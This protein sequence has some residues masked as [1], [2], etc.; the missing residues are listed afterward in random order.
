MALYEI[1]F[2]PTGGTKK[3]AEILGSAWNCEAETID[4]MNPQLEPEK[5]S[6]SADDICIVAVPSF[7]GRAPETA[8]KRLKK[9]A[10]KEARA[11]LA[12]VYGNREFE[13]TLIELKDALSEAGFRCAA[14]VAAVAEHS[15][16]HKFGAGRPD[17]EDRQELK[18]FAERI[19]CRLEENRDGEGGEVSV[20]GGHPY[21]EYHGVPMKPK[22]GRDCIKCGKCAAECPVQAIPKD[23]LASVDKDRCISCMHCIAICPE[24]ARHNDKVVLF[25][26]EQKMKK[27]CSGRKANSLYL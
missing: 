2:S 26:A 24:Q 15:I 22:A 17:E 16:I 23:N 13:D 12:A 25:A 11:V 20:P 4:L 21:R 7:G 27:A 5:Y 8:L 6:F 19:R 3:V 1:C 18:E 10:G 14:A 9:M